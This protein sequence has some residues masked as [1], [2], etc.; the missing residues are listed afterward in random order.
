MVL[1]FITA[2]LAALGL[3]LIFQWLMDA[4]SYDMP[5]QDVFHVVYLSGD[6]A[7]VQQRIRCALRFRD[8][9]VNGGFLI[10][11]DGGL[12]AEG[13]VAAQLLLRREE[14]VGLCA[15]SQVAEIMKQEKEKFGAGTDKRNHCRSRL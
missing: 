2:M 6:A 10:F 9:R 7:E 15:L 1:T 12:T 8:R 5:R 11:V 3:V 14:A 13:Q 4:L